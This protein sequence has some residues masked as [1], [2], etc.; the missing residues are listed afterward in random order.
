MDHIDEPAANGATG[1]GTAPDRAAG[2]RTSGNSPHG[3]S[4]GGRFR[5]RRS[6]T[7][8][9]AETT[10]IKN[11]PQIT[12]GK[13]QALE[14]REFVREARS[15]MMPQANMSVTAVDSNPAP[16]SAQDT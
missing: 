4:G 13:L 12:V 10:A 8:L 15:A 11:N 1:N 5:Q 3:N 2:T 14:A 6:L 9:E 7:L 16:E